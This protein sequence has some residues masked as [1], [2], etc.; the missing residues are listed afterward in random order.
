MKVAGVPTK[1]KHPTPL[2]M[3]AQHHRNSISTC[4]RITNNPFLGVEAL[5]IKKEEVDAVGAPFSI[6]DIPYNIYL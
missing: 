5:I 1:A 4:R 3:E 2:T 6:N